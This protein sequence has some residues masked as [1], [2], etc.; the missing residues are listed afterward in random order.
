MYFS[1]NM[2]NSIL[3]IPK[4]KDILN[5]LMD[6]QVNEPRAKAFLVVVDAARNNKKIIIT[7]VHEELKKNGV[8]IAYKN[9]ASH[10]R[11]LE[12]AGLID[13][14]SIKDSR[15]HRTIITPTKKG[16]KVTNLLFTIKDT[17]T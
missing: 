11:D 14:K 2:S 4:T 13:M 6:L 5:A 7:D 16:N 12:R 3:N 10:L 9:C 8:D 1:P 15:G 17:F